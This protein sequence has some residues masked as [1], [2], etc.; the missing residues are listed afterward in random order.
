MV[1]YTVVLGYYHLKMQPVTHKLYL[2]STLAATSL[3]VS[4]SAQK[5]LSQVPTEINNNVLD[6]LGSL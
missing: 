5:M 6:Y 3:S 1:H 4:S 2:Q